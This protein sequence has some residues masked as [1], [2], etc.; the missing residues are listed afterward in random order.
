MPSAEKTSKTNAYFHKLIDLCV[1]HPN[2]LIV[3]ID[4]V[5]SKQMQDIRMAL[6]GKAEV[7][8]G[9]NTTIRKALEV[10]HEKHPEAGMEKLRAAIKGNVGF[11]FATDCTLDEIREA[12]KKHTRWSEAKPGQVSNVAMN[13]LPGPT[14][15]E[16]SHTSFLSVLNIGTKVVKG[17][18]ELLSEFPI[19]K[20]GEI[21][22]PSA[23]EMLSRLNIKPF[24]YGVVVQQVFQDGSVFGAAVLDIS[25]AALMQKFV[26][27][28]ANLAAFGREIGIPTEAGLPH[29]FGTA[30]QNIAA[31]VADIDFTF[32]D[33]EEVKNLLE[34]LDACAVA[35]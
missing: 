24:E 29:M 17:Q 26:A 1:N 6:R 10:G 11:I 4:H 25:N 20:V 3:S 2:A 22:S 5:T 15:M 30:F 21:V 13:L 33:V 31:L 7:L 28:T 16:P 34:D 9:N 35:S 27:G 23:A 18:I 12:L 8:M 32:K 14:G 19:L